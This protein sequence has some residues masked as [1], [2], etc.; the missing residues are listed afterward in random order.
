[1]I[2]TYRARTRTKASASSTRTAASASR[3]SRNACYAIAPGARVKTTA[4]DVRLSRTAPIVERR[5]DRCCVPPKTTRPQSTRCRPARCSCRS[6]C[7]RRAGRDRLRRARTTHRRLAR[8]RRRT[9]PTLA[10]DLDTLRADR[11]RFPEVPRW[12]RL[13]SIGRLLRERYRLRRAKCAPS[14][15][16]CAT[17]CCFMQRCGFDAFAVRADKD[18]D[19]ALNALRR[20][21]AS[22]YQGAVDNRSRCSAARAA[23]QRAPACDCDDA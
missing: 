3:R 14:A 13:F 9:A 8:A 1:M 21:H 20:L 4:N 19:D 23:L 17:S 10:A 7:G 2:D 12:P 11:R 16:C 22:R 6:R 15:T 5:L 18:I